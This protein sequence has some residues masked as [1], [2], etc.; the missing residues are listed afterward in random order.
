MIKDIMQAG[1]YMQVTGGS[2]STYVN[3]YS[4]LQGVGNMRYNTANQNME[5]FDGSNWITLNMGY[6]SV[7]LTGEAE[8]LLDWA[9]QKRNEEFK[10]KSLMEKHPGLKEAYERLEIMKAL[11]LEEDKKHD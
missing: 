4:G 7:G 11:T 2:T 10:L 5:V 3:G 6:A 8:T 9:K 1:R